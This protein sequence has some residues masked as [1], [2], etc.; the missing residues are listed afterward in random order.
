M[1]YVLCKQEDFESIE[2]LHNSSDLL[3]WASVFVLPPFLKSWWEVFKSS[4]EH[5]WLRSFWEGDKLL[6]LAP[7]RIRDG[8]AFFIGSTDLCDYADFITV[9]GR[10]KKLFDALLFY[11]DRKGIYRLELAAVRPESAIFSHLVPIARNKMA[12]VDFFKEDYSVELELPLSYEDFLF[13]LTKKQR[14]EVR[15]KTRKLTESGEVSYHVYDQKMVCSKI[16]EFLQLF[17]SSRQDKAS[18]LN[19]KRRSFFNNLC[20]NFSD[21]KILKLGVVKLNSQPVGMVL[22]FDYQDTVYLYNSAYVPEYRNLSAGLA[23]NLFCINDS[24]QYNKKIFD[25]LK[26]AEDYKM[27]LGGEKIPLYRLRIDLRAYA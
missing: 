18:F 6:G 16:E 15:R 26:G 27:R 8:T 4:G 23:A 1:N 14:H 25:F 3:Y 12:Y 22:Y 11:L 19:L 20:M 21:Y 2:N 7:L 13:N 17:I 10:E 9:P 5:L 24:I